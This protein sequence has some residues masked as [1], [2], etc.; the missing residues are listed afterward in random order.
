VTIEDKCFPKVNSFIP[1]RQELVSIEE[2]VGKIEAAKESRKDAMGMMIFARVEALIAGWGMEEALR[3]AAAYCEAGADG[4]VIHSKMNSPSEVFTFADL[5]RKRGLGRCPLI[6]IPTTYYGVT[7]GELAERGF[8]MVI[9]ANHGIRA[10]VRSLRHTF[11]RIQKEGTSRGVEEEI[12]SLNEIFQLQ[13]MPDYQERER[14]FRPKADKI[15]VVIPA[16]A[17]HQ[18][19][20]DLSAYLHDKPLCMLEINGKPL[21]QQ[22]TDL[23]RSLGACEVF[24]VAGYQAEKI[25]IPDI[26]KIFNQ[27]FSAEGSASSVLKG[28]DKAQGKTLVSYSDIL[29]DR[30]ICEA[31]VK[32]PYPLTLVIDRAFKTLPRRDK[33][34][35]MV[36]TDEDSEHGGIR[37]MTPSHFK[38]IRRIGKRIDPEEATHEFIGLLML[39]AEG[40]RSLKEIWRELTHT[41]ADQPFHEAD[42]LKRASLTDLLQEL[43]DRGREIHGMVIEHGWS[44]I[45]SL[46]DYER[47]KNYFAR[48]EEQVF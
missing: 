4:I 44:E 21:L 33:V 31:L 43:V 6:A 36:L 16:A 13:G 46:D 41:Q 8:K 42:C 24:V 27:D 1:G 32:S 14:F 26:E 23:F 35:D 20:P 34:P 18:F 17:D 40:L 45:Y 9:Y 19:Q 15:Q 10:I 29:F 3:R 2:F 47:I 30:Q 7:A 39:S 12:A 11:E 48:Q 38:K 28:L 22:Q 37:K 25:V 5:W